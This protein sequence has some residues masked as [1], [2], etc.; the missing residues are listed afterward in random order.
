MPAGAMRLPSGNV[1]AQGSEQRLAPGLSQGDET[2]GRR[3]TDLL[4]R[5]PQR[6]S[7]GFDGSRPELDEQTARPSTLQLGVPLEERCERGD[8]AVT[9]AE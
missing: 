9:S 2:F 6:A 8:H 7:Q 4:R 1:I 5:V 3:A